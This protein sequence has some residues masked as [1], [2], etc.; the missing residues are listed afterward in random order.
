[1]RRKQI[2]TA[3]PYLL[4]VMIIGACGGGVKKNLEKVQ[5]SLISEGPLYS[6]FDD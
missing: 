2:I 3:L 4:L 1:M 6:G 5:V